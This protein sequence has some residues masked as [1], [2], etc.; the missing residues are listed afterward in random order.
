MK[1]FELD[2][3]GVIANIHAYCNKKVAKTFNLPDFDMLD[4]IHDWEMSALPSPIRSYIL[5]IFNDPETYL[6]LPVY[7]DAV[8]TVLSFNDIC[9]KYGA[10]VILHTHLSNAKCAVTRKMWIDRMQLSRIPVVIDAGKQKKMMDSFAV[11]EDSAENVIRSK[12]KHKILIDMPYNRQ[13][14]QGCIRVPNLKE[15]I[16]ILCP[17]LLEN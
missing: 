14:S 16:S 4:I 10:Y 13:L 6:N 8:Q 1:I 15:A 12:S 2:I 17:L 5:K 11:I 7:A 3:D 9:K